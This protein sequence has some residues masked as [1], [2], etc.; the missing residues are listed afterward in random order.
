MAFAAGK[1]M[2]DGVLVVFP[3]WTPAYLSSVYGID[4]T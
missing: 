2:T 1:F 4:F 3:F